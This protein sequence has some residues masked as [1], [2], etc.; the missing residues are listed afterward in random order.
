MHTRNYECYHE[1]WYS[2]VQPQ[3]NPPP[4]H[5]DAPGETPNIDFTLEEGATIPSRTL[6]KSVIP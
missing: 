1:D 4:V 5:V 2:D 3:E 6:T